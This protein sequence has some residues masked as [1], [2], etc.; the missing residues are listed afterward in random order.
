M[1]RQQHRQQLRHANDVE[2]PDRT[3]A[4][5]AATAAT[6]DC[7]TLPHASGSARDAVAHER[8]AAIR[9]LGLDGIILDGATIRRLRRA[10]GLSWDAL[11]VLLGY[12]GALV[13]AWETGRRGCP[14][15]VYLP[16]VE[17]IARARRERQ[18]TAMP[19]IHGRHTRCGAGH[20]AA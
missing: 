6:T 5:T 19:G 16:L 1:M 13:R 4:A 20:H 10:A 3:V 18:D 9:A 11:A 15:H 12:S 2:R 17:A 7:G 8:E 14:A